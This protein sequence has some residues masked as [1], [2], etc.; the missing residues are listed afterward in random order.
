MNFSSQFRAL[1]LLFNL[2]FIFPI[3]K[4]FA[5]EPEVSA[6]VHSFISVDYRHRPALPGARETGRVLEG[7]MVAWYGAGT[8]GVGLENPRPD[9]WPVFVQSL[10]PAHASRWSL[11]YIAGHQSA[12]GEMDFITKKK[13]YG[14][15]F[16]SRIHPSPTP[17]VSPCWTPALPVPRD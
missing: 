16:C 9:Q 3:Q 10:P 5:L 15:N 13:F 12:A 2:F 14:I 6:T 11:V 4:G 17:D 7:T 1:I 8:K